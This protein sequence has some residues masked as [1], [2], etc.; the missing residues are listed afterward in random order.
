M[1][2]GKT[3]SHVTSQNAL[4]K[5]IKYLVGNWK[6]LECYVGEGFLHIDSNASERAVRP[7]IGRRISCSAIAERRGTHRIPYGLVEIVTLLS[8]SSKSTAFRSR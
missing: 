6:K 1:R 5:A 4:G 2:D 8:R 3:Q 7:L